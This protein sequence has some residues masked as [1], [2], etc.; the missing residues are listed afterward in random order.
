M[1]SHLGFTL[2]DKL[3]NRHKTHPNLRQA[4][5]EHAAAPLI[6]GTRAQMSPPIPG[7]EAQTGEKCRTC[8]LFF[9]R[10]LQHLATS[11]CG[12]KNVQPAGGETETCGDFG[13]G[14]GS[15]PGSFGSPPPVAHVHADF[16]AV[17]SPLQPSISSST[18]ASPASEVQFCAAP[19]P[20]PAMGELT[21]EMFASLPE[22]AIAHGEVASGP[23]GAASNPIRFFPSD[24]PRRLHTFSRQERATMKLHDLCAVHNV[25]LSFQDELTKFMVEDAEDFRAST[26]PSRESFVNWARKECG[27]TKPPTVHPVELEPPKTNV[28]KPGRSNRTFANV[29][30]FDFWEQVLDLLQDVGLFGDLENLNVNRENPFCPCERFK[31]VEEDE[32]GNLVT[33]GFRMGEALDGE[34]CQKRAK[35]MVRDR[36]TQFVMPLIFCVDKTGTDKMCRCSMEPVMVTTAVLKTK[37]RNSPR[38][39]RI[40]GF[41]PELENTSSATKGQ[42]ERGA[43][44]RNCH[45]CLK[46]LLSDVVDCQNEARQGHL[47]TLLQLGPCLRK[48]NIL[49]PLMAWLG[50][51]KSED[52]ICGRCGS[53]KTRRMCRACTVCCADSDNPHHRCRFLTPERFEA[54]SAA[55]LAEL[56]PDAPEVA[57]LSEKEC[58]EREKDDK[59]LRKSAKEH[60]HAR[61]QHVHSSAF[62]DVDFAG[63]PRGILGATPVDTMHA[64]LLGMKKCANKAT[65]HKLTGAQRSEL[66]HLVHRLLVVNRSG[67]RSQHPRCNFAKG[68]TNLARI[69][70]DEQDGVTF[71][72]RLIIETTEGERLFSQVLATPAGCGGSDAQFQGGIADPGSVAEATCS[73]PS[74]DSLT[75]CDTDKQSHGTAS[76]SSQG[77]HLT[78]VRGPVRNLGGAD[79]SNSADEKTPETPWFRVEDH[80][81]RPLG[82]PLTPCAEVLCDDMAVATWRPSNRSDSLGDCHCCAHHQTRCFGTEVWNPVRLARKSEFCREEKCHRKAVQVWESKWLRP[83]SDVW[84]LC[85][86]CADCCFPPA[87]EVESDDDDDSTECADTTEPES[88]CND[89]EQDKQKQAT[90]CTKEEL[91]HVLDEMLTFT[92]WCKSSDPINFRTISE[93]ESHRHRQPT[94]RTNPTGYII[95]RRIRRMLE[96]IILRLPRLEGQ[97]WKMQKLH[98]L[99]HL[100]SDITR[101]GPPSNFNC[102]MWESMLKPVVKEPART[103]QKRGHDVFSSQVVDRLQTRQAIARAQRAMGFRGR[104]NGGLLEDKKAEA[105]NRLEMGDSGSHSASF[106]VSWLTVW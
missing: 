78:W 29:C 36:E 1:N 28:S 38:G 96:H 21:D 83:G 50:D 11:S 27:A 7:G 44:V 56:E 90:L 16:D 48:V 100:S 88:S 20:V 95:L 5:P 25:S 14:G 23:H 87:N 86:T 101:F 71:T 13:S 40:L 99:L 30:K 63:D 41:I 22:T 49:L 93:V 58:K 59:A 82:A 6:T 103:S 84:P 12:T 19:K 4:E 43:S 2:D 52:C 79:H 106:S 81:T 60:L 3:K 77:S 33:V 73:D 39:A 69:T 45:K 75:S 62:A 10:M 17:T 94:R 105:Q 76:V 92:A 68:F 51:G 54:A 55:V 102:S 24:D 42:S 47:E 72:L 35:L 64:D 26:A 15:P 53:H 37:V 31:L 80:R 104:V 61:S 70:S 8:G 57:D 98:E 34:W 89:G 85:K 91:L 66:D 46:V 97:G 18:P 9:Q 67:E 74:D 32:V 65:I